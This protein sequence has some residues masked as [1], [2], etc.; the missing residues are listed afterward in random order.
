MRA[1][2]STQFNETITPASY[3]RD[4]ADAKPEF[5][6]IF[7]V[8]LDEDDADLFGSG[9]AAEELFGGD[10]EEEDFQMDLQL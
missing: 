2:S 5:A 8:P 9:A 6:S 10:D 3:T 7:D 4:S 1:A